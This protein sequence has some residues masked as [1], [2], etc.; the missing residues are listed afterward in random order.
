M[1]LNKLSQKCSKKNNKI[2]IFRK[3]LDNINI[4]IH[5]NNVFVI[6]ILNTGNIRKLSHLSFFVKKYT[7]NA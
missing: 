3:L 1:Q 7:A 4:E 2:P 6:Y 5:S